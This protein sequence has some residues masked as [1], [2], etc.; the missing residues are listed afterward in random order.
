MKAHQAAIPLDT[1][2][3]YILLYLYPNIKIWIFQVK[4]EEPLPWLAGLLYRNQN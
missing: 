3:K 2:W 1:P 4:F